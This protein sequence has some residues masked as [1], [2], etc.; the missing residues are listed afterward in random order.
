MYLLSSTIPTYGHVDPCGYEVEVIVAEAE[1]A[2]LL[3]GDVGQREAEGSLE[4]AGL[5]KQ[6][7]LVRGSFCGGMLP[8]SFGLSYKSMCLIEFKYSKASKTF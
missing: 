3:A 6:S 2:E 4:Q 1:A 7:S 8:R 5:C